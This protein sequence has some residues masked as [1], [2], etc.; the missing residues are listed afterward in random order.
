MKKAIALGCLL[1]ITAVTGCKEKKEEGLTEQKD[2]IV[3]KDTVAVDN[4]EVEVPEVVSQPASIED[5]VLKGRVT[6]I[7]RGK[8]GYTAKIKTREGI[9]Y[10]ATIS[11]P[12]LDSPKQFR[13]VKV[14]ED[15]EVSGEFWQMGKE[16][17]IKVTELK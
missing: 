13:E 11:I 10:F 9:I 7:Q 6:D 2:T 17:H 1:T 4:T 14:G 12:N 15:I 8:D 16:Q 3:Q 5:T